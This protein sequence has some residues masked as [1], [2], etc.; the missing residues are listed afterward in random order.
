VED[1]GVKSA[2]IRFICLSVVVFVVVVLFLLLL[3]LTVSQNRVSHSKY[4]FPNPWQV[5]QVGGVTRNLR[6]E[7]KLLLHVGPIFSSINIHLH[8]DFSSIQLPLTRT[9][10][11]GQSYYLINPSST[12]E[13]AI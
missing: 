13:K 4:T 3:L 8:C 2:Y 11:I 9:C 10:T 6:F 1:F 5:E 12:E 7:L